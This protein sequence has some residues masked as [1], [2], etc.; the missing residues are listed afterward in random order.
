MEPA[1]ASNAIA[2][3]TVCSGITIIGIAGALSMTSGNDPTCKVWFEV[4]SAF[5]IT[6]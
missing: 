5:G 4:N 6:R 3:G 2:D 1:E